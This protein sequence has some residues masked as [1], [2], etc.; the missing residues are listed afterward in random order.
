MF[1]RIRE[2][3]RERGKRECAADRHRWGRPFLRFP[4]DLLGTETVRCKRCGALGW[5][6]PNG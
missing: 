6:I 1:A 5:G 4:E 3:W 2:W